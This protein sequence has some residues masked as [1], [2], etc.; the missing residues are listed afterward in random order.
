MYVC[1]YVCI[2]IYMYMCI[3]IY[4]YIYRA[5]PRSG[6][7]RG[8]LKQRSVVVVG[9]RRASSDSSCRNALDQSR[10]LRLHYPILYYTIHT[11]LY[12]TIL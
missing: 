10:A 12:Y 9:R 7:G 11:L 2:Y 6:S 4:I 8:D 3:Y 5:L 1:M